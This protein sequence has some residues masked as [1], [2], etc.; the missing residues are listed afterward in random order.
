[1]RSVGTGK[2]GTL[3]N[4]PG[5][6]TSRRRGSSSAKPAATAGEITTKTHLRLQI[7]ADLGFGSVARLHR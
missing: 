2:R 3:S 1:V 5:R 7:S 6:P 4:R